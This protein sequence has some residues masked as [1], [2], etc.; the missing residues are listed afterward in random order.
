MDTRT[1]SVGEK[2]QMTMKATEE[3]VLKIADVSGD[4]NPVHL[5]AAYAKKTIF[6]N[7]I[8]HGLFCMGMVSNLVGNKLPGVG[9]IFINETVNYRRPVY[10]DDVITCEVSILEIQDNGKISLGFTCKNEN[11][12]IVLD[13]TTLVK[14]L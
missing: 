1:F 4:Y 7:R 14:V 3:L 13:G 9:S 8:A 10:I 2:V 12:K 6:G 5:D 11:E